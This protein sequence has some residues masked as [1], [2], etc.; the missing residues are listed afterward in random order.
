M[1]YI[2]LFLLSIPLGTIAQ[3]SPVI[4]EQLTLTEAITLAVENNPQIKIQR[5]QTRLAQSDV[6][7]AN[8]GLLPTI[9]AI[10][11]ATYSNNFSDVTLRTFQPE[12]PEINIEEAGVESLTINAGV[13]AEYVLYDGK[14]GSYRYE[15]LAGQSALAQAQQHVLINEIAL[16]V[17]EVYLAILKLQTRTEFLMENIAVTQTR[18]TKINDRAAFGKV[19][20][21]AVLQAKTEVNQDENKL[22]ELQLAQNNLIKDLNFLMGVA[23]STTYAVVNTEYVVNLPSVEDLQ[24]EIRNNNPLLKL[25]QRGID[26]SN[27]Q[28]QL[29]EAEKKPLVASFANLGLF[30]QNNDVQ[31][32]KSI[33]NLGGTVGISASYNLY[34]GGVN[35]HRI[36]TARINRNIENMRQEQQ[37]A[38]L[39][40]EALKSRSNIVLLQTQLRRATEN[41]VTYEETFKR[42]QDRFFVGKAS[43]LDVRSAQLAQLNGR[44][45][46]EEIK[47]DIR[48]NVL[49][50]EQLAGRLVNP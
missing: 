47:V 13:Q 50:L 18:L 43:N 37:A 4:G 42:T 30:Y 27:T 39:F 17:A 16:A 31:Q 8:A 24:S 14:R 19:S 5:Q 10:T 22:D 46:I 45:V 35:N 1:K 11:D 23:P 33:R 7:K 49:Q 44:T 25:N 21:L 9:D 34:D 15:L 32:L 6:F 28:I 36:Q 41:L 20:G 2:W 29:A 12:P 3:D 48:R 40:N 38:D 26:L